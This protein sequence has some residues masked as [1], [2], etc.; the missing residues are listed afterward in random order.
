M[1]KKTKKRVKKSRKKKS[2]YKTKRYK[3]WRSKVF[4]RDRY[5]CQLCKKVGGYIE[6]HHIKL[7]SQFPKL[8]YIVSNGITLCGNCHQ[9]K[10]HEDPET[11]KKYEKR[12]EKLAK[13][14]KPKPRIIKKRKKRNGHKRNVS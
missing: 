6:A 4:K 11:H 2:I 5:T 1:K 14:N 12:F 13:E 7:K 3:D 10:V 8:C 9:N